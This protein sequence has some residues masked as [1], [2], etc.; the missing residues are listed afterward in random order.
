VTYELNAYTDAPKKMRQ[1]YSDLHQN[2]QDA[3]NEYG[4]Q[5]MSPHYMLDPRSPAVVPREHW[6]DPPAEP[7]PA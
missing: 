6:H 2:I 7:P 4:V 5:I 1:I 3:F